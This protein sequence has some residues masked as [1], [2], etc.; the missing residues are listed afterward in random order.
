VEAPPPHAI[1]WNLTRRCNLECDH[2]YL[3]AA[4]R[5]GAQDL[6]T[7]ACLDI[8]E[9]LA[10]VNRDMLLIVTGGEPVL[11][12]DLYTITR[13]AADAGMTV[14]LG[15]NGTLLDDE[16]VAA[17]RDAGVSGVGISV[18]SLPGGEHDRLRGRA[19]SLAAALR[20]IEA[21]KRAGLSFMVQTSVFR[22]NRPEL[23]ELAAFSAEHGAHAWNVYFLVCTGRGQGLTDLSSDEYE[24]A[25]HELRTI[26]REHAGKLMVAVRCA[27]HFRRVVAEDGQPAV[28]FNAFPSGCP[29]AFHY[30]RIGPRGELTPCPYMPNEVGL[31]SEQRLST[32]WQNAPELLQLRDRDALQGKCGP[33]SYRDTCGGCRARALAITG[34]P[35]AEDP[36]CAWDPA[37]AAQPAAAPA[38]TLGLPEQRSMQWDTDAVARLERVPSFLRG[39]VISRV[40]AEARKRGVEPVTAEIMKAVRARQQAG[41][42]PGSSA[43]HVALGAKNAASDASKLVWMPDALARLARAPEAMRASMRAMVAAAARARGL[44]S[45]DSSF[46]TEISEATNPTGQDPS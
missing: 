3:D 33:C 12:P 32:L 4:G 45:I 7:E 13:A 37:V 27:P 9:Q 43:P 31:L 35:M 34:D 40:E 6:P 17:L 1:S 16:R 18:D 23:A 36:S 38:P 20:G 26:Q 25:L 28:G 19:G 22:W 11:R 44:T 24:Q 39:L 21:C 10:E 5:A 41:A 30:A 14:V 15:T 29:A 46:L 42:V 8:V 2:C